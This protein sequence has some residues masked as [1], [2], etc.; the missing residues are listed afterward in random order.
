MNNNKN[1]LLGPYKS[2][3]NTRER[4]EYRS[5]TNWIH[6]LQFQVTRERNAVRCPICAFAIA[7]FSTPDCK[8]WQGSEHWR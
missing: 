6:G 7:P 1:M 4:Q 5:D 8:Q 3:G 2:F